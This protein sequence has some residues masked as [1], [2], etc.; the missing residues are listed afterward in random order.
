L[1]ICDEPDFKAGRFDTS[2]ID[3]HGQIFDYPEQER[4][5]AKLTKLI[6]E[7]H[8]KKKNPYAD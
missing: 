8:A 4:E 3:T 5:I 6:A 1:A 7:I 2:Y